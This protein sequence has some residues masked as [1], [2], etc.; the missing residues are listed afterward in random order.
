[1]KLKPKREMV[2][3]VNDKGIVSLI[4]LTLTFLKTGK[5]PPNDVM[6]ALISKVEIRPLHVLCH[7][8]CFGKGM[9][10]KAVPIRSHRRRKESQNFV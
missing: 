7:A 9:I 3:N 5:L 2:S 8:M 10:E 4:T 1:M 6:T